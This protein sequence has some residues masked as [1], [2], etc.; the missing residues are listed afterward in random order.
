MPAVL[1][2]GTANASRTQ[3]AEAIAR[4]L[5]PDL[6]AWSAGT[7]PSHVKPHVREVLAEEAIDTFGLRGKHLFEVPIDDIDVVVSLC[8]EDRVPLLPGRVE[9]ISWPMPDPDSAPS[10]EAVEAYRATRDELMRRLPEFLRRFP[11]P[12]PRRRA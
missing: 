6:E 12:E 5:R 8:A 11:A 9:R 3:L 10:S 7:R 2:L 4:H 1:F